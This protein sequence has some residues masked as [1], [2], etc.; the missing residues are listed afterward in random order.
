MAKQT[1]SLTPKAQKTRARLIAAA[2]DIIGRD[3]VG[4]LNV[5]A[6]CDA[7]HV[8]RTSFYNYFDDVSELVGEVALEAARTLKIQF[9]T[10]HDGSDRGLPRLKACLEMVLLFGVEN[11]ET[12]L[13]LTS[14]SET[15]SEIRK[16]L[17]KEI[18]EELNGAGFGADTGAGQI[19]DYL[20]VALLALVREIALNGARGDH[21]Q[22]FV[23]MMMAGCVHRP[24]T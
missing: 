14:L 9:D 21:A 2:R 15:N 13:L 8:G 17:Q 4:G 10:L 7:A 19:S 5:M 20:T 3:G 22:H 12:A 6:L 24:T 23:E 18:T 11:P 1:D 16:M